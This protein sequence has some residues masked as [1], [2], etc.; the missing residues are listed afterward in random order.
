M[1]N[2]FVLQYLG[3]SDDEILEYCGNGE[4]LDLQGFISDLQAFRVVSGLLNWNTFVNDNFSKC[5]DSIYYHYESPTI[6]SEDYEDYENQWWGY[7]TDGSLELFTDVIALTEN[8]LK[9]LK[10]IN[11]KL[12]SIED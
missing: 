3:D 11:K 9:K 6:S 4:D 12:K 7:D 2:N 1:N 8:Y 5:D 10:E